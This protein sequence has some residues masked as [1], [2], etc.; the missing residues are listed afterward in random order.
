MS[1]DPDII[2]QIDDDEREF[3]EGF[4]ESEEATPSDIDVRIDWLLERIAKR[5]K[6]VEQNNAVAE[7]RK[8]QIEAWR[9]S[10][11]D[12]LERAIGYFEWQIRELQPADADSFEQTYGKR[13]RSLPFGSFGYRKHPDKVEIYDKDRALG[14]AK[15]RGLEV[16]TKETV[17]KTVLK[18]ALQEAGTRTGDGFEI[19]PG[20]D[21]FYVSPADKGEAS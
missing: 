16:K 21:E 5:R 18:K 1:D 2:Q 11:N 3:L 19:V 10:E 8:F 9:V 7:A 20:M 4:G 13:S 6:L 14:W 17:S 15:E 12:R